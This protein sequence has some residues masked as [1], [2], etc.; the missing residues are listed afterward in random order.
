MTSR[1]ASPCDQIVRAS[2]GHDM[3]SAPRGPHRGMGNNYVPATEWLQKYLAVQ[4]KSWLTG[5]VLAEERR[6]VV[7]FRMS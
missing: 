6:I 1:L 4:V 7:P 3:V 5:L 2:F